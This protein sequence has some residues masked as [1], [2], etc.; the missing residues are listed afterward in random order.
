MFH[1]LSL[2]HALRTLI[3]ALFTLALI[4]G[5]PALAYST[6]RKSEIR[7]MP[8][9]ALYLSAVLSQWVLTLVGAGV[10]WLAEPKVF[11]QGFALI[12]WGVVVKWGVAVA[13]PALLALTLAV[14]CERRGWLERES[15]LV[16]LLIPRCFRE[17][18]WA[19]LIIAPTAALCEEFLF[20]GYLL[21]Q[22][23]DW[24]HSLL[25]AWGVSSAAFGLAHYYQGWGGIARAAV[26]GALLA[27]PVV[28]TGSLYPAILA[29]WMIDAVALV[30]LGRWMLADDSASA[31]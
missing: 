3:A 5:V 23:H 8:R 27:Y 13:M 14:Y 6:A 25:W 31:G 15:D 9:L 28:Q 7:E 18:V 19:V 26:L 30:W 11:R 16:Y 21:M 24:T 1:S 22:L 17:R 2:L 10:V 20:R 29:H 4:V 12:P